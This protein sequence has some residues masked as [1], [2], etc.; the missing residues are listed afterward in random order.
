MTEDEIIAFARDLPGV[1]SQT[2]GPD[3]GSPEVAWGD[4]FFFYDPDGDTPA[5][6]RFPF[7]TI[8]TSDYPDFDTA[9]QLDRPGT[10]RL[11]A[12]VSQETVAELFVDDATHDFTAL[13][14]VM[15][16]PVYGARSWVSII[17]P[18][19][20]TSGLAERL[21]IEAHARAVVRHERR[22]S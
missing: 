8:V 22:A 1:E 2:A 18:G 14:T 3:D 7:A 12:W 21:L 19:P 15:P 4:T 13:D 5:D 6:R 9:S 11:N 20:S 16:H 17:N 10:F